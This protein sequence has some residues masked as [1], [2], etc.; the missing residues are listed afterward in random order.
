MLIV[1]GVEKAYKTGGL[2]S[3]KKRKILKNISF[4][5]KSGEG[6]GIIG[7]SGSGKSTLGRLLNNLM[8]EEFCLK[9]EM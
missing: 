9:E 4:E 2:F 1:E 7:E 6:L 3:R 8:L 5:C